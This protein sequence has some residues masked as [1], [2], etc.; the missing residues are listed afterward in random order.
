MVSFC[1]KIWNT[2][3]FNDIQTPKLKGEI[4]MLKIDQ[5][6]ALGQESHLLIKTPGSHC[7]T[8]H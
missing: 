5:C 2:L 6:T 8:V 4:F 7:E 1:N 3:F